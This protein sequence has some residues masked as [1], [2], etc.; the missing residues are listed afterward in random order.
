LQLKGFQKVALAPGATQHLTFTVDPA[1]MSFWS[2]GRRGATV[3]PGT[4]GVAVGS[5]SR[6]LRLQGSFD[7]RGGPL[8][9]TVHQAE[10][11]TVCC[12]ARVARDEAGYTGKG[13]VTGYTAAGA[14][15]TF[16]I[17]VPTSGSCAVTARYSAALSAQAPQ[18]AHTLSLYVNGTRIRQVTFAPLAN[19]DTWDFETE[20]VQL[21]AGTN[22]ISYVQDIGDTGALD[23]DALIDCVPAGVHVGEDGGAD[24]AGS[25]AACPVACA[26]PDTG[27]SGDTDPGCGCRLVRRA[28]TSPRAL[29]LLAFLSVVTILRRQ[30]RIR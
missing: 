17:D 13:F 8:S 5:S 3:Y 4:Y 28:P 21:R 18:P 27:A 26:P 2:A 22:K 16:D 15:T 6:D 7:V 12:D 19:L 11:A 23:L 24:D 14:A 1:A 9:G 20:T 10:A 29:A 30:R 25:G